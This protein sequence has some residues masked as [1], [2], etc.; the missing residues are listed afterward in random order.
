[1]DEISARHDL[2]CFC[3]N[4]PLIARWDTDGRGSAYLHVKVY[5]QKRLYSELIIT[6][7]NEVR[8]RCR[9]C[10]RWHRIRVMRIPEFSHDPL[11]EAIPTKSA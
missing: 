5:K 2:R 4:E 8:I 10:L 3:S 1:M 6:E 11:P 7:G 9:N